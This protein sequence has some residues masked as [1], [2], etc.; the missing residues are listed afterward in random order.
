MAED[1]M[2]LLET[3]RK[4]TADGDV[5]FLREGVRVLAEAVM[6]AEVSELTGV[7]KGERDPE[8]RLTHRNGYRERRWDTRVGTIELAIPRVRDGSYFPSLLEPR[9]RAERALLAVVQEAYVL[10]VSTRRVEDLVQALG[11]AGISKSEVSRMCAA[12]D[13][14]V[15]AFRT[16]PLSGERVPLS[17]ARR[18]VPQGPR[19]RPG[20]VDGGARRDGCRDHRRAAGP[21]ARAR[22]GQRRGLGLA[23]VHPATRRARP[24]A[25]SAWS[26]ATTT[27][28]SSRRSASSCWAPPGSA[29]GSI[30]PAT[31][32]TSCRA[33]RGAWSRPPSA[34]VFEQ[35]DERSARAELRRVI[36]TLGARFPAVA[37]LLSDAEPDLL[38]HFTF[39]ERHRRQIRS[40]NPLERLNK[41]IKR[42]TAVVGIFPNRAA[43]IRLVGMVLAE[44]D[45]EWQD[46]RRYF[47]PETMAA[48]DTAGRRGGG[49]RAAH[50]EL[51][52]ADARDALL[53]HVLGLDP[54][55]RAQEQ[56]GS[57]A[58]GQHWS[59]SATDGV[60]TFGSGAPGVP[61]DSHCV[62]GARSAASS[63]GGAWTQHPGLGTCLTRAAT[64]PE[65][66]IHIRV[67]SPA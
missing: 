42:R 59:C 57:N 54:L 64:S 24:G 51:I 1:R 61:R 36:D 65:P 22:P 2:A 23:G 17:V 27:A 56:E 46:G 43:V 15:E 13:A 58:L 3:L 34:P 32:R 10:G 19:G 41:E 49:A 63:S 8:R 6:E 4:A 18:D 7:A 50:G 38:A 28:G 30:S 31:P 66:T 33:R 39:P 35:P 16:R 21:G 37:D 29:A 14:E 20:R 48:I 60:R 47:R 5:D 55:V 25:A 11:I 40:T 67:V 45:D 52:N 9:R 26:S 53:H 12:L 44:Q 62:I